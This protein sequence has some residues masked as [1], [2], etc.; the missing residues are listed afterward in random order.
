MEATK[1]DLGVTRKSSA[2]RA[3]TIGWLA[4]KVANLA[5]KPLT[6][7]V[8]FLADIVL[9]TRD[10][11]EERVREALRSRR[12]LYDVFDDH[13]LDDANLR[14]AAEAREKLFRQFGTRAKCRNRGP[15]SM[16]C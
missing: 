1:L 9:N 10:V 8:A 12:R 15:R 3:A 16:G 2:V 5:G 14:A 13:V 4:E 7:Q 11:S 6:T